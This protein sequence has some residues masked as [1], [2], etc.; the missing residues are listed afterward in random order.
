MKR[1]FI[2]CLIVLL[3]VGGWSCGIGETEGDDNV[4]E[5]PDIYADYGRQALRRPNLDQAIHYYNNALELDPEHFPSLIGIGDALMYKALKVYGSI[6]N[7]SSA[8]GNEKT[9]QASRSGGERR[10]ETPSDTVS[11]YLRK[12]WNSYQKARSVQPDSPVPYYKLGRLIFEFKTRGP[13]DLEHGIDLLKTAREKVA[14]TTDT[15]LQGKI[16]FYLGM[17]AYYNQYR[18]SPGK[19]RFST[20]R[21][22]LMRY[23]K[24]YGNQDTKPPREKTVEE[25]LMRIDNP[26]ET[27]RESRPDTSARK[28]ERHSD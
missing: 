26:E 16:L 22:V 3:A 24:L 18:K 6:H 21:A 27:D 5:D 14:D 25:F 10:G 4:F 19:R 12:A 28:P 11:I 13:E 9:K 23:L 2:G 15:A 8:K 17:S 20:A 1:T 7:D